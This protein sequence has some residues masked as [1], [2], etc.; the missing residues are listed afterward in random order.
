MGGESVCFPSV[1]RS[2]RKKKTTINS[3][4]LSIHMWDRSASIAEDEDDGGVSGHELQS[5]VCRSRKIRT[6]LTMSVER[7]RIIC[8][9]FSA[10]SD[11]Q[12]SALGSGVAGVAVEVEGAAESPACAEDGG[13]D[14]EL[15]AGDEEG[16]E[17]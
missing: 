11:L 17:G 2:K 9:L 14:G 12:S 4:K 5:Q 8:F 10:L 13:G 15:K 6:T 1:T 7:R 3:T 16:A